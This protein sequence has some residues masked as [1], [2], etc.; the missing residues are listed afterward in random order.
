MPD[1]HLFWIVRKDY[2]DQYDPNYK[3]KHWR[4]G[5]APQEAPKQAKTAT[6]RQKNERGDYIV[7]SFQIPD[8]VA[9][10]AEKVTLTINTWTGQGR[11]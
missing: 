2:G 1:Y 6:N 5:G 10:K 3:K 4:L 9:T 8:R 11:G 7:T